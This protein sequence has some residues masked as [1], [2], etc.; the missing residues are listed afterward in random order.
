MAE[1]DVPASKTA[2]ASFIPL[3]TAIVGGVLALVGSVYVGYVNNQATVAVE[4]EKFKTSL[5]LEAV[6]V[7]DKQKALENLT[8]FVDAGFLEDPD[9]RIKALLNRNVSPVLPKV[10][11]M[12][13]GYYTSDGP[14]VRTQTLTAAFG[15]ERVKEGDEHATKGETEAALSSYKEALGFLEMTSCDSAD[16]WAVRDKIRNLPNHPSIAPC[17]K[18]GKALSGFK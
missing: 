18:L 2:S 9:G 17:F 7:G 13:D 8:F 5:V 1:D 4:R 14:D 10:S 12:S 3:M 16:A 6:R 15:S 11:W